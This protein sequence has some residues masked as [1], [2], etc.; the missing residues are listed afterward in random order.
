MRVAENQVHNELVSH[1][2]GE[3]I[4]PAAG[5]LVSLI[6]VYLLLGRGGF[7]R[8]RAADESAAPPASHPRIAI[9][10][11]ARD[12]AAVVGRALQSLCRQALPGA[13]HIFLVDDHSSDGTAECAR[14]AV[15]EE[16]ATVIRARALPAGWTGKLWAVSEG[17]RAA[18]SFQPDY[19]LLTDAD[20]EYFPGSLTGLVARAE[21]SGFDLVSVMVRLQCETQAE[22][23]LVPAFV[24]FFFKLYPP[25][26]IS[27]ARHAT[28]GA[29][30]GCILIRR[31]MLE[32]IGGISSIRSEVIDDCALARAVKR[33]GGKVW[34]GATGETRS[35]RS[36]ASFGAIGR[37]ISRSAFTQLH[38]STLLLMAA[39]A[40]MF[41]TYVAPVLLLFT[42][43][44][45]AAIL[46]AAAWLLMSVAYTPAVR[47]YRL[48]P[49]W[50]LA[51][52]LVAMFY[53]GATIHSAV[54]YWSGRGGRWKG[55]VQDPRV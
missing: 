13:S 5:I 42:G 23:A 25:A 55:R 15:T 31:E 39:L 40:G 29:A 8:I 45:T 32:R 30:G 10:V 24:F 17:I 20:I 38:H 18:E 51:L 35:I 53:M 27:S 3:M 6:W 19:F 21:T 37:M 52:P 46:G 47:F 41:I 26:W 11:P 7:W 50:G 28:A 36:Y 44:L 14:A 22:K 33:A 4:L 43:N 49:F 9:V 54:A 48:S 1:S 12:E 16:M 2:A 34:L